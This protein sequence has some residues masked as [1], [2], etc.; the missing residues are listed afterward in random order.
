LKKDLQNME[1]LSAYLDDELSSEK[2][3]VEKLLATSLELQ[4]KLSDLKRIKQLG[5]NVKRIP[6]S[7]FFETRLMAAIEGQKNEPQE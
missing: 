7:P 5:N 6:E 3:E 4:K 2:A 1:L